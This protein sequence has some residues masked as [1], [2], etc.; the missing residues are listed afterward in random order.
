MKKQF[1]YEYHLSDDELDEGGDDMIKSKADKD[2]ED[3]LSRE[4]KIMENQMNK[5]P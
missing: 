5:D 4:K 1:G 3:K 2:M